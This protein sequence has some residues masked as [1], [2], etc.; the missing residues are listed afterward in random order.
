[1]V[2]DLTDTLDYGSD[3]ATDMEEDVHDDTGESSPATIS[4]TGNW[5]STSTYN[6]Y[7]VDTPN[8]DPRRNL[9]KTLTV[10]ARRGD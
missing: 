2:E 4:H 7:M 3:D 6:I 10:I 5:A 1:M 9:R 8:D